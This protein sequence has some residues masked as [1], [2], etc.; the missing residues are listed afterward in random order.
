[1]PQDYL[2]STKIKNCYNNGDELFVSDIV[3]YNIL[4]ETVLNKQEE[5]KVVS[6]LFPPDIFEIFI[7]NNCFKSRFV[8]Y[9][10]IEN[11]NKYKIVGAFLNY[12]VRVGVI[13]DIEIKI[14]E[15]T[16]EIEDTD[17][18]VLADLIPFMQQSN[19]EDFMVGNFMDNGL[20]LSAAKQKLKKHIADIN[21]LFPSQAKASQ[22]EYE[23]LAK[24][25]IRERQEE[26]SIVLGISEEELLD[27]NIKHLFGDN[28]KTNFPELY[29]KEREK[30]KKSYWV[31]NKKPN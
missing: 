7:N 10:S 27:M 15:E 16:E 2:E 23:K 30:L 4:M 29:V 25:R 9:Y 1:M 19:V 11:V 21:E 20:S 22:K 18:V 17:G 26:R 3:A 31:G 6:I 13:N 24:E 5:H 14:K 28:F 12:I 8:S